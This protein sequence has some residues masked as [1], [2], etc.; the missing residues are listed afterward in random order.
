MRSAPV[1]SALAAL[2]LAASPARATANLECRIDDAN[3]VFHLDGLSGDHGVIF[4]V[5][6]GTIRFKSRP[7][8]TL[9]EE[10][11]FDKSHIIQQWSFADELRIEIVVDDPARQ[12]AV[13]LVIL[14]KQDRTD[15]YRGRY[16]LDVAYPGGRRTLRGRIARCE[17]G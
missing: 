3:L 7:H 15:A 13:D 4:R 2:L 6:T 9:P 11:T 1:M 14:A 8:A 5:S 17:A 16:L 10:V 12:W